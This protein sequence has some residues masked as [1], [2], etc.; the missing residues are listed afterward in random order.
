MPDPSVL[1]VMR[2]ARYFLLLY[3]YNNGIHH[4]NAK[5]PVRTLEDLKGMRVMGIGPMVPRIIEHLGAV[6]VSMGMT[7]EYT[8]LERGLLDFSCKEWEGTFSFNY[9]QV[10]N[11]R[12]ILKGGSVWFDLLGLMMNP[13]R[14]ITLSLSSRPKL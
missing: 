4:I 10:T 14:R 7:E 8:S 3:H 2:A 13:W 12:T 11:H 9:Y 5:K 1:S 6:P